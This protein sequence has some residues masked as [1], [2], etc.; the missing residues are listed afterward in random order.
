MK[1][2]KIFVAATFITAFIAFPANA[3][4]KVIQSMQLGVEEIDGTLM[5]PEQ[6]L[7]SGRKISVMNSL[8]QFRDNYIQEM[9][10][11]AEDL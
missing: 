6:G 4:D 5:G 9:I 2:I 3:N 11:S 8:I 1:T 7:L 10:I